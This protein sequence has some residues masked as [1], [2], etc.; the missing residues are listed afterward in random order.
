MAITPDANWLNAL[1][2]P[3]RVMIGVTLAATALLLLDYAKIID[4]AVFGSLTRPSMVVL[5]VVAAALSVSGLGA[6]IYD[7]FLGK[8]KRVA[9][10]LRRE[11]RKKETEGQSK[12]AKTTALERLDY[13]SAEELRHLADCLRKNTQSFTTWAHSSSASTLAAK[14]LIYTPSGTHHQDYFPFTINDFAWKEL[15]RRK[16]EFIARDDENAKQEEQRKR[17]GGY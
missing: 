5:C 7:L 2:L 16:D 14:R 3:L 11:I 8:H 6:A 10:A 4:L 9:I 17:R 13:L 15:L 1:K 12:E